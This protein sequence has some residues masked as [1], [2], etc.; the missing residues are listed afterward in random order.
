MSRGPRRTGGCPGRDLDVSPGLGLAAVLEGPASTTR[1]GIIDMRTGSMLNWI[2]TS[3]PVGMVAFSPDGT[4]LV[5][6]AYAPG[7][8][9]RAGSMD[10]NGF[11]TIDL[12]NG[13]QTFHAIPH[14]Q[15]LKSQEA[16]DTEPYN[17]AVWT[18][19]GKYVYFKYDM[20]LDVQ[21]F[22]PNGE[23]GEPADAAELAS[24]GVCA[25]RFHRT[26][27]R[28]TP[29]SPARATP[30]RPVSRHSMAARP[31]TSPFSSCWPGR[32]TARWWP[33]VVAR[34]VRAAASSTAA[35]C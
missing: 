34:I 5:A 29:D 1:I 10:R 21:F 19:D 8:D 18:A 2:H 17:G 27:R 33:G 13:Q 16:A 9:P 4:R 30:R 31:T 7:G 15:L 11:I 26:V 25:P 20:G 32:T 12:T 28:R 35:L 3:H 6:T 23:P 22:R 14:D 24:N